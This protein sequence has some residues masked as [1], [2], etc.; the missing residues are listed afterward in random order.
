[1]NIGDILGDRLRHEID[2]EIIEKLGKMA[3]VDVSEIVEQMDRKFETLLERKLGTKTNKDI[4]ET[5]DS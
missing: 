4:H 5:N 2:R 3:D 1:M